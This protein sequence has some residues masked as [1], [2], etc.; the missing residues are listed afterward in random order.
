MKRIAVLY[1]TTEGQTAKI[2]QQVAET[3]KNAG[4]DV[5]VAEVRKL[6]SDMQLD[7]FD[8]VILGGSIHVGKHSPAVV[9]SVKEN[10]R[11]LETI[12]SAFFS[13]SL[14]AA[15]KTE[16]QQQNARRCLDEFLSETEWTPQLTTTFAGALLYRDYGFF[17]RLMMKWIAKQEGGDTDTSRNYE[18][19]DWKR[20]DEFTQEF[21][22]QFGEGT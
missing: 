21:L 13:V 16:R 2:A 1:D 15:G 18:Y 7:S 4:H 14:S 9:E 17:K 6:P 10:R 5:T 12:P 20:V 11:L 8:G 22:R 3:V 19:T